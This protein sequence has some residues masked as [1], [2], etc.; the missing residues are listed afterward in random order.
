MDFIIQTCLSLLMLCGTLLVLVKGKSGALF[1]A[2]FVIGTMLVKELSW[3]G[4]GLA[5]VVVG[6]R[7]GLERRLQASQVPKGFSYYYLLGSIVLMVF[8]GIFMGPVISLVTWL[9][10]SGLGLFSQLRNRIK[11]ASLLKTAL[12]RGGTALVLLLL[13]IYSV[14]S[15]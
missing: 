1:M 8:L 14:Y 12:L 2:A 4:V 3:I 5:L 13:G 15:G 10:V 9:L 11:G 7:I 6:L